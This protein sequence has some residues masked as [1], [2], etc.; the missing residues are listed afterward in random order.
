MPDGATT[1]SEEAKK[2]VKGF[3]LAQSLLEARARNAGR[4]A[5][6]GGGESGSGQPLRFKLGS[7]KKKIALP[8]ETFAH[9]LRFLGGR[10]MTHTA[11]LVSKTWLSKTRL[12]SLWM[13]LDRDS[14]MTNLNKSLTMKSFLKVIERPQFADV[15]YLSLPSYCKLG[16]T[17][18]K[19]IA[20]VIFNANFASLHDV[21][22]SMDISCEILYDVTF[23]Y[24][25]RLAHC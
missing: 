22:L 10:E 6:G 25:H 24:L 3:R 8:E 11:G 17:T 13:R 19:Q 12:P 9:V 16:K 1:N 7:A 14:G 15:H 20:K 23:C 5:G 18:M 4:I 2:L 21:F